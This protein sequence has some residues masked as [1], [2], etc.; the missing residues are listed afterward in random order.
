[1][2]YKRKIMIYNDFTEQYFKMYTT[3]TLTKKMYKI[4]QKRKI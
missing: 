1:M 2:I 4:I 3:N